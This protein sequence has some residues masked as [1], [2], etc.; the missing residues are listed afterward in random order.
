M[1]DFPDGSKTGAQDLL[2]PWNNTQPK[3]ELLFW[4]AMNKWHNTWDRTNYTLEIDYVKV[5]AI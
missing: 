1:A 3:A 5:W 4:R 2:K